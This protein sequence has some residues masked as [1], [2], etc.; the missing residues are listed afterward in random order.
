MTLLRDTEED[1]NP[2]AAAMAAAVAETETT[3]VATEPS[4]DAAAPAPAPAPAPAS[5]AAAPTATQGV[6]TRTHVVAGN[7]A[8]T[9]AMD[10]PAAQFAL[11]RSTFTA[12]VCSGAYC[13]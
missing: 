10:A 3:A 11:E 4:S 12:C 6:G 13:A 7:T 9:F 8:S 2:L 5:A 1:A